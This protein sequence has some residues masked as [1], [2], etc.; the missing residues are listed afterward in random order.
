MTR[1]SI[2]LLLLAAVLTGLA[3]L[4]WPYRN[5]VV[6]LKI[7]IEG[8][9]PPFTKTEADGRV[10]GFEIDLA[11]AY[12]ERLKARCELIKLDFDSLLPKLKAGE[13][14]AV[15]ASLTITEERLKQV[16]F[17]E[18]YYNVPSIWIARTG[19]PHSLVPGMLK[20]KSVSVLKGSPRENWARVQYPEAKLVSAAKETDVY[21][22]LTSNEAELGLSSA[23]VAKT[24]FLTLPEGKD[25]AQVG[26]PVWIGNG[27]GVAVNKG[28]TV[29]SNRF[30][31]AIAATEERGEYKRIAARYFDFD[32]N[33]RK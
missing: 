26:P 18:S 4:A 19:A 12:C 13:V 21:A 6:P 8:S 24:K 30:N 3:L 7:G 10:T 22:R 11:N 29:L 28:N 2:Y 9:Y 16:D 1:R 14:D 5:Y 23:L 25:F 33:N 32:I 15:M 20:E 31:R 27:V 17:S